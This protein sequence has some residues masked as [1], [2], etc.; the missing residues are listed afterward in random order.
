[1]KISNVIQTGLM[2]FGSAVV[3]TQLLG[4]FRSKLCQVYPELNY[5]PVFPQLVHKSVESMN[6][7]YA[8][9]YPF[10]GRS[11][12]AKLLKHAIAEE[13]FFRVIVQE[14]LLRQIPRMIFPSRASLIDSFPAK[15]I[16]LCLS[17]AIFALAHINTKCFDLD[18]AI[19]LSGKGL[20]Y[21]WL[22]ESQKNPF[23]SIVWHIGTN[24]SPHIRQ[25]ALWVKEELIRRQLFQKLD[26]DVAEIRDWAISKK[27][28]QKNY[29]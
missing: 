29:D 2:H 23:L 25:E 21:G 28:K 7:V 16:R 18:Y 13:I 1:M 15:F 3:S 17:S 24:I 12:L 6:Q 27:L 20:N 22:Q 14:G 4:F 11:F 26:E 9:F 19:Y 5:K 10:F 8:Y